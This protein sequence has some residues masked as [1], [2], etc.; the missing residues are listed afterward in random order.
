MNSD[1]NTKLLEGILDELRLV[2]KRL[3]WLETTVKEGLDRELEP[4]AT[5]T[6]SLRDELP[7]VIVVGIILLT[8]FLADKYF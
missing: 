1:K 4:A 2:N 5:P 3:D 8:I 7:A 6:R